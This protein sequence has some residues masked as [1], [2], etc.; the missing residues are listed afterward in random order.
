MKTTKQQ[1]AV[2]V[3]RYTSKEGITRTLEVEIG[4][5]NSID[6][7]FTINKGDNTVYKMINI[8]HREALSLIFYLIAQLLPYKFLAN[9]SK[10]NEKGRRREEKKKKS[11]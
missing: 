7:E 3:N 4:N 11:S 6:I 5:D 8:N 9:K 1:D 2:T 10:S